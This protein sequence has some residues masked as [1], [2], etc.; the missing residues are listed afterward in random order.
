E[1]QARALRAELARAEG[2][3]ALAV[4]DLRFVAVRAPASDEAKS[5]TTLLETLDPAHP[6][7]GKERLGRA[8]KLVEAGRTDDALA[9]RDRAEKA[10]SPADSDD[11]AWARAFALYKSRGRYE[12]AAVAFSRLAQKTGRRQAEALYYA[13]RA[14]SRAD[15]DDE[16]A[17][18][19]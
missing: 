1:V 15:H 18:G 10:P 2:Q 3:N 13:A 16:A 8:E 12:K 9:D 5:A 19:Y 11:V 14:Q 7:T 17:S 4:D 6:L